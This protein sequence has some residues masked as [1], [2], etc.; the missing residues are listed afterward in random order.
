[1]TERKTI[2]VARAVAL[3]LAAAL[4]AACAGSFGAA[5]GAQ[6]FGNSVLHAGGS[7]PIKHVIVILQENRT[8]DNMFHGFPG[9]NTVNT[10]K[11]HGKTYTLQEIALTWPYDL[12][13]DHSQ[14]LEDYDQGKDDGFDDEI[15]KYK[16]GPGCPDDPTRH[17]EP[18]CWVISQQQMWKQMAYSYVKQSDVQQ[19]WTLAS[20][21][22]LGDDAFASNSG[23]TYVA[24]QYLIAG[25]SGHAVE[26]PSTQPWGC[27]GPASETVNLLA[28]GQANPPVFSKATGHEVAGP[29]TCFTYPTIADLLDNAGVS[30]SYYVEKTGAGDNLNGFA[31]IQQIYKGPDWKNVKSPD[32]KNLQ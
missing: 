32:T 16:T 21:Y 27:G 10:G 30:W 19:Y 13:H 31:A 20:E 24:H 18:T 12:N 3:A 14:F 25:E 26:V 28:Y 23:P 22:A 29:F 9:A 17:N 4:P 8:F 5:P 15:I 6:R 2:F 7:T 11:G 1:M